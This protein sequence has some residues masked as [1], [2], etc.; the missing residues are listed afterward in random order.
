MAMEVTAVEV[1]KRVIYHSPETP[2]YTSWA[3]VW[4]MPDDG[5]LVSFTQVMGGLKGWRQRAP[6]EILRR[7]PT[8]QQDIPE[9]D[10]TGLTQE[11]V[12]LR[13][14]DRGTTWEPYG[15]DTFSSAMNGYLEG[16]VAVLADG[17]LMRTGWGQSL[18]YCDVKPTGFVQRSTD[19]GKSWGAPE[20]LSEEPLLQTYPTRIRVLRDGR[21]MV[22]GGAAAYD[23]ATWLWM[24]ML[25]KVRHCLWLGKDPLGKSWSEPQCVT[26]QDAGF[27]CEEWDAAEL[28]NGDLLAVFRAITYDAAGNCTRQDRRQSVLVKDGDGWKVAPVAATPFP[29]SGHPELLVTREGVVLHVAPPAIH[30]TADRGAT[31][32]QLDCP[33]TGYYAHAV[34][35]RDGTIMAVGHQGSDDPYGKTDQAIVMNRFRLQVR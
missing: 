5:V 12:C 17:S 35:L 11:N 2:G 24:A 22:T 20:Y 27:A 29:H 26:P 16:A 8:A 18:T 13:S 3:G 25:P 31:W 28:D 21:V 10:M 30:W 33:G 1:E 32:Q 4:E 23:P 19:A 7:L 34:Q 14:T 9:Y 6:Q 15:T